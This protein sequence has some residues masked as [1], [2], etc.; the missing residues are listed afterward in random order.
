[1]AGEVAG[2]LGLGE[3]AK[4]KQ[5]DGAAG[6]PL[7]PTTANTTGDDLIFPQVEFFRPRGEAL[8]NLMGFITR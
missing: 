4:A 2:A 5:V 1:M 6:I 8:F 3:G 7:L